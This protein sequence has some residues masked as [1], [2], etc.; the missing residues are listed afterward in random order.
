MRRALTRGLSFLFVTSFVISVTGCGGGT[1]SSPSPTPGAPPNP[2]APPAPGPGSGPTPGL[3]LS[4]IS[5]SQSSVNSQA[6]PQ[7]TVSMTAAAPAG[8][9]TVA[10][11]SSNTSAAQVPSSVTV[12]GGASSASFIISTS[13]VGTT[14]STTITASYGGVTRATSLTVM[15]PALVASYTVTSP[16]K[17]SDACVFGPDPEETDC[18]LDGSASRGFID[19]FLFTYWTAGAPIGHT[20]SDT[21]STPR[22][23]T[24]CA[25]FEGARGGDDAQGNRYIQMTIELVVQDRTGNRSS[26][27]RRDVRMYP[28]RMCGF[29][30]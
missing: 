17:G 22:I 8:G 2:S 12:V 4:D 7:G 18:V 21:R 13:T 19:R 11:A 27:V 14:A 6:Q 3:A 24:R 16:Q 10:L 26:A 1:P 25:F 23:G 20:T 9:V 29:S 5:L 30:Y 28:N 15:P